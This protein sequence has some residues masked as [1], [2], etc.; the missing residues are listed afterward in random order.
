M[1]LFDF[2]K[3][4]VNSKLDPDYDPDL[5]EYEESKK[6]M[7]TAAAEPV[8][9]TR[10]SFMDAVVVEVN[11]LNSG[12]S[13]VDYFAKIFREDYPD[14]SLAIEE[15]RCQN[16]TVMVLS[17][18]GYKALVVELLSERNNTHK[19]RSECKSEGVPYVRFYHDHDGWDN[20]RSYVT[21]RVNQ[22]LGR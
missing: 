21:S 11:Q 18:D 17:K 2:L 8:V 14:Y 9:T 10:R 13:Y 5:A 20:A 4:A 1:G 19:L 15:G 12:L 3:N 7:R 6:K 22:A 16:S